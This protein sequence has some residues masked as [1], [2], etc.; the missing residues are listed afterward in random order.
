MLDRSDFVTVTATDAVLFL[1]V[2]NQARGFHQHISWHGHC[3]LLELLYWI[4][5]EGVETGSRHPAQRR[6]RKRTG[7]GGGLD[8]AT[9]TANPA[10][11]DFHLPETIYLEII[12]RS[13]KI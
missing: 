4:K 11:A 9:S 3:S 12:R 8:L 13:R 5:Q 10:G 6:V 2:G 7:G 1:L